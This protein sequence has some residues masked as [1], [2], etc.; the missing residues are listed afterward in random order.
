MTKNSSKFE[1]QWA[2]IRKLMSCFVT[3]GVRRKKKT[4]SK[5]QKEKN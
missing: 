1:I 2:G 3:I 5:R 4:N